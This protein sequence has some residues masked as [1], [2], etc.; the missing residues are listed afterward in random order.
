MNTQR[1]IGADAEQATCR[2][3]RNQGYSIVLRNYRT[4]LGEIDIVA[5]DGD[6][7]VFVEV[8]ARTQSGFGGPEAAVGKWKRSRIIAAAKGFLARYPSDLPVRF[9]VVAWEGGVVRVH[10]DAFQVNDVCPP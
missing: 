1:E 7:L 8:K 5:R 4:R 10:R 9:D 3:L 6:V 2:I